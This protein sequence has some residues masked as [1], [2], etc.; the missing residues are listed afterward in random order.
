MLSFLS[1][2]SS[3]FIVIS[4]ISLFQ[5]FVSAMGPP[6]GGRNDISDRFT[7]HMNII[8]I[9]SFDDNTMTKIFTSIVD[10]HFAKGFDSSF[11]RL[12]KVRPMLPRGAYPYLHFG[13][14][15]EMKWVDL[16]FSSADFT[17]WVFGYFYSVELVLGV[18]SFWREETRR[19]YCHRFLESVLWSTFSSGRSADSF[20]EQ[21]LVNEP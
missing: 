6:G 17:R 9:D 10:W 11:G 4:S 15:Y 12:G 21:Q 8:S 14:N 16:D 7:R 1:D 19:F 3:T 5:L 2:I 20:P 18:F 13:E